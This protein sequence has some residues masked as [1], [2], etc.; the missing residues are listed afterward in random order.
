M[1][2]KHN[3]K[4]NL[5]TVDYIDV[6]DLINIISN[7]NNKKILAV[8]HVHSHTAPSIKTKNNSC[9]KRYIAEWKLVLQ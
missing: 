4:I 6:Y 8:S 7:I 5:Q 3:L 2:K 1:H 9:I